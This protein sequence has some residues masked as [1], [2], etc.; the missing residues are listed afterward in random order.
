MKQYQEIELDSAHRLINHGPTS[1]VAT[2]S[3]QCVYNIAPIAWI[4]PVQ[5]D[6][7][8]L[9]A[10]VG[11]SHQTYR[12]IVETKEFVVCVPHFSQKRLIR[13]TGKSTGAEIDKFR[14]FEIETFHANH[15]D[16][17]LPQGCLGFL[18]CTVFE[19]YAQEKTDIIVG[20]ILSA[21]VMQSVF[22]KRLLVEK[23][24]GKT[25]HHL[26]GSLFCT[27]SDKLI[28]FDDDLQ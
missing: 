28:D 13:Q 19:H 5:K 4:S 2:R 8:K 21:S 27:A 22:D 3:E 15:L 6:P 14:E 10:V 24:A 16:F 1:L 17:M 12:N 23:A 18:E 7:P 25:L 20:S 26:G 11:H 9:L